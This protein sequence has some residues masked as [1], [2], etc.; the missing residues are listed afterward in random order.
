M[1]LFVLEVKD[2]SFIGV[3]L[4]WF[5]LGIKEM[6]VIVCIVGIIKMG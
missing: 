4:E 5:L 6:F 1:Y 3:I 2:I